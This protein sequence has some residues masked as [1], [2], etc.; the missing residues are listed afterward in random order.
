VV[1]DVGR[2]LASSQDM[3]AAQGDL[4]FAKKVAGSLDTPTTNALKAAITRVQQEIYTA[5]L[6]AGLL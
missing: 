3:D 5:R 6:K 4:N 1:E 2:A